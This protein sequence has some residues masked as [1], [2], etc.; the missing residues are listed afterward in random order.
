MAVTRCGRPPRGRACAVRT[1]PFL[2]LP[3]FP[4]LI[5]RGGVWVGGGCSNA[6]WHLASPILLVLCFVRGEG[7]RS[8]AR[9][10]G[11]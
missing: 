8:V 5:D 7:K 1:F 9:R 3:F 6:R 11:V 4:L 10:V 2:L